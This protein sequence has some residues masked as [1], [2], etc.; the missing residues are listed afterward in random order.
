[1]N[2]PG[3][4]AGARLDELEPPQY[5]STFPAA[6]A[7]NSN[8]QQESAAFDESGGAAVA[9]P[10][11]Y[12]DIMSVA[13]KIHSYS[14]EASSYH[15]L[16][17]EPLAIPDL[18]HIGITT[19]LV[20]CDEPQRITY[21][22]GRR[23]AN[24]QDLLRAELR[25]A[26]YNSTDEFRA[27][28]IEDSDASRAAL[29]TSGTATSSSATSFSTTRNNGRGHSRSPSSSS[30]RKSVRR[31]KTAPDPSRRRS[32]EGL[33]PAKEGAK[34]RTN[35]MQQRAQTVGSPAVSAYASAATR[36]PG[37]RTLERLTIPETSPFWRKARKPEPKRRRD[38]QVQSL[39]RNLRSFGHQK[40][41][42]K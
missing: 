38:Q 22:N 8:A 11:P 26:V 41:V 19:T 23:R 37:P 7:G 9:V 35:R 13:S 36:R 10:T 2:Q 16:F 21:P 12:L 25:G 18:S 31:M 30:S 28:D 4:D 5:A 3:A 34:R 6:A 17:V 15:R 20:D 39:L 33:L 32:K 1:M 14:K 27:E 24:L 42:R 29:R 40:D